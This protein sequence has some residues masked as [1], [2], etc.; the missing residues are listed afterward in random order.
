[1][2][3]TKQLIIVFLIGLCAGF[4]G[5]GIAVLTMRHNQGVQP[6]PDVVRAKQFE[7]V[8]TNGTVRARFGLKS[9]DHPSLELFAPDGGHRLSLD[10][11]NVGEPVIYLRDDKQNVRTIWGH[12]G[13]DTASLEDDNWALSFQLTGED[14]AVAEVGMVNVLRPRLV[15]SPFREQWQKPLKRGCRPRGSFGW[16]MRIRSRRDSRDEYPIAGL[17]VKSHREIQND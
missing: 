17:A 11:D 9:A 2:F 3:N 7:V 16:H 4:G 15:I 6:S 14:D 8:T 12:V 1:M 13:S 5:G 10:L